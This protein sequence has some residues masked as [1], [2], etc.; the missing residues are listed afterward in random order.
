MISII[1]LCLPKSSGRVDW[2]FAPPLLSSLPEINGR[3]VN[4]HSRG[5]PVAPASKLQEEFLSWSM[6]PGIYYS[7]F[8]A[9]ST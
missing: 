7:G 4:H 5:A 6:N 8:P 2:E 1:T 3:D 9:D